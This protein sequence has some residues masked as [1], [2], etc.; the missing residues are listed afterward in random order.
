MLPGKKLRHNQ[1]GPVPGLLSQRFDGAHFMGVAS[2]VNA[3]RYQCESTS[4]LKTPQEEREICCKPP[5]FAPF[6]QIQ[7]FCPFGL[8][9]DGLLTS[10]EPRTSV[11]RC[12]CEPRLTANLS[13]SDAGYRLSSGVVAMKSKNCV[14]AST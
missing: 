2:G 10:T 6:A 13:L 11:G 3:A 7:S 1:A 12:G 8:K 5:S 4:A 9:I 14:S